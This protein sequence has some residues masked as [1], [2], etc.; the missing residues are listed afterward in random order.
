MAQAFRREFQ[1][2]YCLGIAA[3]PSSGPRVATA[4]ANSNT[5]EMTGTLHVALATHDN[6]RTKAFPLGTHPT[7]TKTRSAKY[8]LNMLRLAMLNNE[9]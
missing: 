3:F 5:T 8:A 6:V 4:A 7:I 1:A 9:T 2:D